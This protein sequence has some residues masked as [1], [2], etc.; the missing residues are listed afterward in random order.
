MKKLLWVLV[1]LL[2]LAAKSSKAQNG[3]ELENFGKAFVKAITEG[4]QSA[5]A[6]LMI[7]EDAAKATMASTGLDTAQQRNEI[8]RFNEALPR[9]LGN[10]ERSFNYL[11]DF[12]KDE[13]LSKA[14]F[15]RIEK[16]RESEQELVEKTDLLLY[17]K[18]KRKHFVI[19]IDD[20]VRT[21]M[22]WRFTA[23]FEVMA[24]HD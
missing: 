14:E 15:I 16:E 20:C 19:D 5:L 3:N 23:K 6:P 1:P 2:L 8:E 17:F 7:S 9:M 24:A 4:Q 11:K 21:V 13:D 12:L 18:I 10:F 22:G